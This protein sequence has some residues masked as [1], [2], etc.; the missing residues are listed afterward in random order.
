MRQGIEHGLRLIFVD[1]P[2]PSFDCFPH[3]ASSPQSNLCST[4]CIV[5]FDSEDWPFPIGMGHSPQCTSQNGHNHW[6]NE[7]WKKNQILN[8][9]FIFLIIYYW[10]FIKISNWKWVKLVK[11]NSIGIWENVLFFIFCLWP[12][13]WRSKQISNKV[14]KLKIG[15]KKTAENFIYSLKE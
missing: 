8:K 9:L 7:I 5:A 10:F 6:N 13:Y 11:K 4:G 15:Y 14:K 3:F 12:L 2:P 1:L